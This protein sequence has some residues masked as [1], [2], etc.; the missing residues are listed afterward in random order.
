M[1]TAEILK[2]VPGL[3]PRQLDHWMSKGY[4]KAKP[5]GPPGSRRPRELPPKEIRVAEIMTRLVHGGVT[6]ATAARLARRHEK[7]LPLHLGGFEL[8]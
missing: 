3:T 1:N 2:A 8:V 7:G 6:P 5:G 4:L